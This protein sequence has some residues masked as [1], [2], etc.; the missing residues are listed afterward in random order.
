MHNFSNIA[1][2]PTNWQHWEIFMS[3]EVIGFALRALSVTE[4][5]VSSQ[6]RLS[7]ETHL[8]TSLKERHRRAQLRTKLEDSP[9]LRC[10]TDLGMS[11]KGSHGNITAGPTWGVPEGVTRGRH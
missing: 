9:G 3:L 2:I 11:L 6:V 1:T 4:P 5:R 8:V 10:R 7:G